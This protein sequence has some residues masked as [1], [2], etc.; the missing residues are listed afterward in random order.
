MME[1]VNLARDSGSGIEG[2]GVELGG[3]RYREV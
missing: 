2:A 3:E 1:N